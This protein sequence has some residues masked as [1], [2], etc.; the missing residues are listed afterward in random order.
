MIG[1]NLIAANG[2]RRGR[3]AHGLVVVE[4]H[5]G[6]ERSDPPRLPEKSDQ[7]VPTAQCTTAADSRRDER[8][9]VGTMHA[10]KLAK[11]YGRTRGQYGW[12]F[13]RLTSGKP[14]AIGYYDSG[15]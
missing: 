15:F 6:D 12:V 14:A 13:I 2:G 4:G 9:R 3:L 8:L 10:G 7:A 11:D 5:A 1:N